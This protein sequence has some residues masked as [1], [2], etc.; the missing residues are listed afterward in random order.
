[1]SPFYIIMLLLV[2]I[3]VVIKVKNQTITFRDILIKTLT[4]SA[5]LLGIYLISLW[6]F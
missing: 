6:I 5:I 2:L 4:V 1:M 3:I